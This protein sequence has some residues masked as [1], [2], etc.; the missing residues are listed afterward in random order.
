M[1]E[2][3]RYSTLQSGLVLFWAIWLTIATLT[4]VFDALNQLGLI[5]DGFTFA[6]YNYDLLAGTVA[7]HGVPPV[8]AVVLFGGV[9]AWEML[10]S[11]LL[12]RAWAVMR[13]GEPGTASEVTQAFV[14][15]LALW[16]TF[17]IATELTVNYVT[18]PTH[19]STL[20]AQLA[21]LLVIRSA[22]DNAEQSRSTLP[23]ASQR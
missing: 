4:N 9:L 17:L 1:L 3:L 19:K 10:A 16:C 7:A 18:A 20:I 21:T 2:R 12:W 5:P 6:S 23:P 13:R 14:V 22:A 11:F 15:S 8:G